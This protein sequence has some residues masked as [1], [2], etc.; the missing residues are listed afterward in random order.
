MLARSPSSAGILPFMALFVRSNSMTRLGSPLVVTPSHN[1]IGVSK[2]QFSVAVPAIASRAASS[3]SQ[4]DTSP[5][6]VVRSGT[7]L[8]VVQMR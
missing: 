3:A 4:S 8:P 5:G 7:A 2:D 6:L 1:A